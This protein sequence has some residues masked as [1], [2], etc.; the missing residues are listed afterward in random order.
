M[1]RQIH[2]LNSSPI[3]EL[4]V[5]FAFQ[6]YSENINKPLDGAYLADFG[7][8][9]TSAWHST[10]AGAHQNSSTEPSRYVSRSSRAA[11][12]MTSLQLDHKLT[13]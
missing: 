13:G 3:L 11:A 10:A 6:I 2:C 9:I 4:S 8:D 12:I 7:I 1:Y 5:K